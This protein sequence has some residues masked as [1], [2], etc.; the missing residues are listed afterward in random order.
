M[1]LLI[2][3]CLLLLTPAVLA[4]HS[5]LGVSLHAKQPLHI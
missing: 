2:A 3:A 4:E 1:M 5:N